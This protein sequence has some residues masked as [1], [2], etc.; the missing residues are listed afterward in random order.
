MKK[1]YIAPMMEKEIFETSDVI[2]VS[3]NGNGLNINPEEP[4]TTGIAVVDVN[5]LTF[6]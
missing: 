2:T 1:T 3:F 5:D 6:N 4:A